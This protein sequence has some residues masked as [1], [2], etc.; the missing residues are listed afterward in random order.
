VNE[1]D[2]GMSASSRV[3]VY[4]ALATLC[5]HMSIILGKE[6]NWLAFGWL[7]VLS[8]GFGAAVFI[9]LV[10][11]MAE[12]RAERQAQIERGKG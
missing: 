1:A 6:G 9:Q 12:R 7:T 2:N 4:L 5:G 3:W 11:N 8:G 10:E